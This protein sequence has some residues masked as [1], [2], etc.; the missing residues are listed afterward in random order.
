MF[1]VVVN[2]LVEGKENHEVKFFEN[3]KEMEYFKKEIQ[4]IYTDSLFDISLINFEVEEL[5]S[6]ELSC[7]VHKS[8]A[9]ALKMFLHAINVCFDTSACCDNILFT[10][11]GLDEVQTNYI[12]EFVEC[13]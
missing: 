12:N 11:T 3:K 9:K 1:R 7:E 4:D 8:K 5:K 2:F 10:F 6:K 13:L